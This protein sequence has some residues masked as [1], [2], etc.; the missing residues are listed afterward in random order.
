MYYSYYSSI[1]ALCV[2]D[3]QQKEKIYI[4]INRNIKLD[5]FERH[6]DI[7]SDLKRNSRG[8]PAAADGWF[9]LWH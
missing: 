4:K 5:S 3:T 2:F 7:K 6:N 9:H 8:E 1:A